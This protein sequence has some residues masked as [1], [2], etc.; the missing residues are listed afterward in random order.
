MRTSSWT[1]GGLR[2][3]ASEFLVASEEW[4]NEVVAQTRR[5]MRNAVA[6][7]AAEGLRLLIDEQ[8][9]RERGDRVIGLARSQLSFVHRNIQYDVTVDTTSITPAQGASQLKNMLRL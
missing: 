3:D 2:S 5:G 9:E 6:A 7:M 1:A 8:R 4:H